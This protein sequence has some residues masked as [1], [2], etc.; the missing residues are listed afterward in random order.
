MS[1]PL[2]HRWRTPVA[3]EPALA[4]PAWGAAAWDLLLAHGSGLAP[5]P[6]VLESIRRQ[7]G[8]QACLKA[9]RIDSLLFH[10]QHQ[11]AILQ[12][13]Y[14]VI[15]AQQ[16]AALRDIVGAFAAHGI[17]ALIL[18]GAEALATYARHGMGALS[19]MDDVDLLVRAGQ[20]GSAQA[21]LRE[22]GFHPKGTGPAATGDSAV[23]QA[24]ASSGSG[25]RNPLQR[26]QAVQLDDA[27]AQAARALASPLLVARD[28]CWHVTVACDLHHRLAQVTDPT[29]FFAHAQAS[30]HGFGHT[31]DSADHLW[32]IAT[33]YYLQV[34][35]HGRRTLRELAQLA[36]FAKR[37]DIDWDWLLA[38]ADEHHSGASLYY[39]LATTA[40][41]IGGII[42]ERILAAL[43]T[44]RRHC[45]HDWG[46][47]LGPLFGFVEQFPS[48]RATASPLL[49]QV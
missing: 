16:H 5:R 13:V 8:V 22:L 49:V 10:W 14:D 18:K 20:A 34:G 39:P 7:A 6:E 26:L 40:H 21:L 47:Q 12:S 29:A 30:A 17:D 3:S 2:T 27:Q 4:V 48:L 43:R 45:D 1:T 23:D 37:E 44:A 25:G 42:P 33:R 24:L 38:L 35:R 32:F 9:R 41:F 28:G 46:W 36:I 19:L 31:L 11:G 15:W